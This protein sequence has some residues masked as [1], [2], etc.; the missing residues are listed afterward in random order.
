M[1]LQVYGIKGPSWLCSIPNFHIIEG[2]SIDYM[3]CVL[4]GISR[5]MLRLWFQSQYHHE[6][7]YIGNNVTTIDDRLCSIKPPDEI[8]RT[9]RSIE[10]TVKFWKGIIT[11][12]RM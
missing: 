3:H 9:P 4:L 10:L 12:V 7:W 8:Q 1:S 2:I 6:L 5:L 11:Y